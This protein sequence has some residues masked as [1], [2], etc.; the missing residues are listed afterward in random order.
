M[1]YP[2]EDGDGFG[3]PAGGQHVCGA[4]PPG[5]VENSFD[6]Y[7]GNAD[8]HPDHL[9]HHVAHRGDGSFDYDCDGFESL[10]AAR[11]ATCGPWP[12][13]ETAGGKGTGW[14]G[15]FPACGEEGA[16]MFDC[17]QRFLWTHCRQ[18]V[19]RGRLAAC[20]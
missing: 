17:D 3:D 4:A 7:D 8:A 13:C 1:R 11:Q 6:C 16:W 9:G 15:S 18:E 20:R 2:D 14:V 19:D 5:F 12:G 10:E